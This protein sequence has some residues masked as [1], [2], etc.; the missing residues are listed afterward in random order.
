MDCACCTD[1][2]FN[3]NAVWFGPF[4]GVNKVPTFLI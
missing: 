4:V 2:L 3:G 1:K